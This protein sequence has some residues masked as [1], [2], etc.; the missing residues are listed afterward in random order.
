MLDNRSKVRA[1][2]NAR[3]APFFWYALFDG[4]EMVIIVV[5]CDHFN[6]NKNV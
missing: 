2:K 4:Q 3:S 1:E 5:V 6:K